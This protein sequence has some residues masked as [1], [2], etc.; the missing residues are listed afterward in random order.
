MVKMTTRY[1][2]GLAM[3]AA[4]AIATSAPAHAILI[5]ME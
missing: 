2:L 3:L 1:L 4:I 5:L